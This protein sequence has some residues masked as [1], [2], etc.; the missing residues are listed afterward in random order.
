M[1][2]QV[3]INETVPPEVQAAARHTSAQFWLQQTAQQPS[4]QGTLFMRTWH[5][6]CR[7]VGNQPSIRTM[8]QACSCQFF[9]FLCVFQTSAGWKDEL[10]LNTT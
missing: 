3:F 1:C 2:V 9:S 7:Y 10:D 5:A 6:T 4:P 8:T